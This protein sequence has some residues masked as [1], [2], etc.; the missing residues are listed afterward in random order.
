MGFP[1]TTWTSASPAVERHTIQEV[2]QSVMGHSGRSNA[3]HLRESDL[4]EKSH[5]DFIQPVQ[6]YNVHT[7]YSMSTLP[8]FSCK[9][10][11]QCCSASTKTGFSPCYPKTPDITP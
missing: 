5:Q 3:A 9:T 11:V 6:F 4:P 2:L 7:H 1:S 10:F 8:N